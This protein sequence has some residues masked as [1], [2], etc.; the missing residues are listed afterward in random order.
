MSNN[1]LSWI[2]KELHEKEAM[3]I[4]EEP[5]TVTEEMTKMS[6]GGKRDGE[7]FRCH[8]C[9]H[10]FVPGDTL[11]HIKGKRGALVCSSCDGPDVIDRW[12]AQLDEAER[13]FWWLRSM[14]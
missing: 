12:R 6:W 4:D 11:R 2:W 5:R 3:T 1:D 9:G 8:L 7:A 10:K 13:R 14:R